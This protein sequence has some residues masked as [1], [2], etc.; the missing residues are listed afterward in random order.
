MTSTWGRAALAAVVLAAGCGKKTPELKF[1]TATVDRGRIVSRVTAT[2]TL[3]ALVTVQVGSQVSGRI[4]ELHVDFNA[5]VKK[6]QV[7]AKIDPQL[8]EAA[9]EQARANSAAAQGELTRATVQAADAQR[10]YE[11]TK[12]LAEQKL[13]AQ[14]ELE[15]ALANA[16]VTR[17]GVSVAEGRLA[18]A[19]ASLSQAKVNL[20]L[21]N[22]LSPINGTVISRSVDVGQTVAASLQAPTLF[23]IAEDLAKMQVDTSVAE[24]DVGKLQPGMP[25]S[26]L[27]DA[28]PSER[29][30]G[31]VRQIRNAPQTVQ[32]VVTYDA[33]IDVAN[34]EL[35]L[36]PGMTANVTFVA[37]EHD[38]V[39]RVPNAAIRFRPPQELHAKLRGGEGGSERG[40]ERGRDGGSGGWSRRERGGE[41]NPT[42]AG[43]GGGGF[44]RGP[45]GADRRTVWVM[46]GGEP[47][48]VS[49]RVGLSDGSFTEL[50]EGDLKEGDTVIT[51]AT[52]GA[53]PPQPQGG[54]GG[55]G[56][57]GFGRVL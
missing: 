28:F 32:N 23:V 7:I 46:R 13:V 39:I 21:T 15:T 43:T 6:G 27:V 26:F 20:E 19:K 12:E 33:V 50:V 24:A 11:R 18:Q 52:G 4:A 34:P 54:P 2:G 5:P 57:G 36:R 44:P 48:P 17:A 49:I 35:K 55:G 42:A 14:A 40:G 3:S 30:R 25:T 8:F 41:G 9:L 38:G 53:Q 31:T 29:F 1:E 37:A 47:T 51:D 22:I 16:N 56:R 45:D 10:Q